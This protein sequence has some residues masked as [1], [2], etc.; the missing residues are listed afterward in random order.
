VAV[1]V[2]LRDFDGTRTI[3]PTELPLKRVIATD[4]TDLEVVVGKIYVQTDQKD[5]HGRVI[6]IEER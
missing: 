2:I 4:E 3:F 6:Y 1:V 5:E